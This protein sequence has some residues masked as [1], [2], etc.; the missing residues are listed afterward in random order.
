MVTSKEE[1]GGRGLKVGER[2][3]RTTGCKTDYKDAWYVR[4]GEYSQYFEELY[5]PLFLV[6]N[7]PL[8]RRDPSKQ[9]TFLLS[10]LKHY[11]VS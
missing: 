7:D 6:Q 2:E 1:K 11:L 8:N 9:V 4:H 10:S 3:V 5:S